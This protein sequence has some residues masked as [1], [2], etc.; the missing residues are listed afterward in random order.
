MSAILLNNDD[1]ILHINQKLPTPNVI[2]YYFAISLVKMCLKIQF[3]TKHAMG[4][5][6]SYAYKKHHPSVQ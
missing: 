5:N 2:L 6:H 3:W 4:I 1:P